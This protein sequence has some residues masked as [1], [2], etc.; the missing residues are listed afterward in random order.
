[1]KASNF[2]CRS[3]RRTALVRTN[4]PATTMPMQ[5]GTMALAKTDLH[6][7]VKTSLVM[8]NA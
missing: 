1:M 5:R 6:I 2:T 8:A 4:Q 3:P 7:G